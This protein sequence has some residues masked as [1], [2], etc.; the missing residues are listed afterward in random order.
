MVI[1][2]PTPEDIMEWLKTAPIPKLTPQE[3][4]ELGIAN[5]DLGE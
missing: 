4:E 1:I 2:W 5:F 3:K